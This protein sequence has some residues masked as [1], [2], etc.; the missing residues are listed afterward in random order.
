MLGSGYALATQRNRSHAAIGDPLSH[1]AKLDSVIRSQGMKAS[2]APAQIQQPDGTWA[3]DF[4]GEKKYAAFPAETVPGWSE[5]VLSVEIKPRHITGSRQRVICTHD[6]GPGAIGGL[7]GV[8]IERDGTL[9]VDYA[10]LQAEH[11]GF[12]TQLKFKNNEW[13][14]L[15][16][17]YAVDK[18][19]VELNS[20]KA[21]IESCAPARHPMSLV[22]GGFPDMFF[23]GLIRN[24]SIDHTSAKR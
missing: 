19:Y 22:L 7:Y 11:T 12:R 9:R 6:G 4:A 3:L 14:K 16:I 13:N 1:T 17:H 20:E 15:K 18:L 8:F 23:D 5:F 24:L 2:S 21:E 10:G